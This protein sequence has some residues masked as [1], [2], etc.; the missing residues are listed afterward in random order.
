MNA[1]A[2]DPAVLAAADKL[3]AT[4]QTSALS[5]GITGWNVKSL[6]A[7]PAVQAAVVPVLIAAAAVSGPVWTAV[8]GSLLADPPAAVRPCLTETCRIISQDAALAQSQRAGNLQQ[9]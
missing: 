4:V 6:A 5:N 1:A 2:S 9:T 7:D 3:V 8:D